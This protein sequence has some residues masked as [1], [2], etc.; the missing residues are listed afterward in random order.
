MGQFATLA[1][2]ELDEVT[3]T[4]GDPYAFPGNVWNAG[5]FAWVLIRVINTSTVT[6]RDVVADAHVFGSASIQPIKIGTFYYGDG[7]ES[8]AE[9]GP[10][11]THYYVVRLRGISAG[12]AHMYVGLSAEIVPYASDW[13]VSHAS[14]NVIGA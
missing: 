2:A 11:Q 5:E 12:N 6:L 14:F 8:W 13:H 3:V 10:S 7:E 4:I 9:I 1:R